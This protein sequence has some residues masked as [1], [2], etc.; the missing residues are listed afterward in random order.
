MTRRWTLGAAV[1][2]GLCLFAAESAAQSSHP[3]NRWASGFERRLERCGRGASADASGDKQGLLLSAR[4]GTLINF[5]RDNALL[6]RMDPNKP[7]YKPEFWDRVQKLDQDGNNGRSLLRLHAP[8]PAA[9]GPA[10]EDRPNSGR[11]DLPCMRVFRTP[12]A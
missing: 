7:V 8:G 9:H 12:I 10:D 4:E 2:A 1:V 5:E 3:W 6:R 11:A